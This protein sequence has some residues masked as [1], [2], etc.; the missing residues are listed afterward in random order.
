[1]RFGG[2]DGF[3]EGQR[4]KPQERGAPREIEGYPGGRRVAGIP[5]DSPRSVLEKSKIVVQQK[6]FMR[7]LLT[8]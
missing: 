3:R 2:Q 7:I 4:E 1:L 6:K 5:T 8:N